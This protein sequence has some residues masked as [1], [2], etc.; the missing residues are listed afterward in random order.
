MFPIS[1][2]NDKVNVEGDRVMYQIFV[3]EDEPAS[4]KHILTLVK[5]KCSKFEVIG[6]ADNG[7]SALEEIEKKRP[8][9]L[10]TDV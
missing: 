2:G 1:M 4:L 7:R 6:T 8:D 10:I 5:L 9:V 3:A